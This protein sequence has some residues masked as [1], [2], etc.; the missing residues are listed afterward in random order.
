MDRS[1]SFAEF[2]S[3]AVVV[4]LRPLLARFG[5]PETIV[6]D[7]GSCFVREEHFSAMNRHVCAIEP[8]IERLSRKSSADCEAGIKE[9]VEFP[10]CS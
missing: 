2:T 8:L 5:I 9:R 6:S 3:S 10:R 4:C 1:Y 7:T